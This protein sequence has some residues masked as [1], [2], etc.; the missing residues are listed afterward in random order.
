MLPLTRRETAHKREPPHVCDEGFYCYASIL[1]RLHIYTSFTRCRGHIS[2]I[3]FGFFTA[4]PRS[5][6]LRLRLTDTRSAHA[7]LRCHS[8][9]TLLKKTQQRHYNL[10]SSIQRA[11][12]RAAGSFVVFSP[13]SLRLG[14]R[15]CPCRAGFAHRPRHKRTRMRAHKRNHLDVCVRAEQDAPDRPNKKRTR[16]H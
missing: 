1:D 14:G 15:S 11:S 2:T 16:S 7:A 9:L 6:R 10:T 3:P 4:S 5:A 13:S 12:Q 8:D